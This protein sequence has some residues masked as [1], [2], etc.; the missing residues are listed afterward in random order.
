MRQR[1]MREHYNSPGFVKGGDITVCPS[2][3]KKFVI[4]PD[5]AGH[6]SFSS[7][8]VVTCPHCDQSILVDVLIERSARVLAGGDP[9]GG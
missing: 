9:D 1:I 3:K 8:D 4:I 7:G 6:T 5:K 2:C